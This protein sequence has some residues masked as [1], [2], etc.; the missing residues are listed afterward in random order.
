MV[1]F[2][3]LFEWLVTDSWGSVVYLCRTIQLYVCLVV[4]E[5]STF[6]INIPSG[7]GC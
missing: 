3:E 1:L 7:Y 2:D 4:N 5:T 6:I